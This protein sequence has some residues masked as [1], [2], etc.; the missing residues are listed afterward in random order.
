MSRGA[1]TRALP[2]DLI[3]IGVA[4]GLS[5]REVASGG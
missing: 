5:F 2:S 3:R 4:N 1:L